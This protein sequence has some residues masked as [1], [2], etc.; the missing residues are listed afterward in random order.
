MIFAQHLNFKANRPIAFF[1][2]LVGV[3]ACGSARCAH[4]TIAPASLFTEGAVLQREEKVPVW[5]T[6]EPNEQITIELNGKT[7]SATASAAGQWRAD[8]PALSAGGPY[9]LKLSGSQSAPVSL[10]NVLV[11]E[12]WLCSGQSNMEYPLQGM[13]PDAITK[14]TIPTVKD[15]L[16]RFAKVERVIAL[17]PQA[18]VGVRWQEATPASAASISAVGYYFARELRRTLGVPVGLIQSAYGGTPAQGWTSREALAAQPG[19]ASY[20]A[21]IDNYPTVTYP[22]LLADFNAALPERQ[23]KYDAAK[24]V[25]DAAVAAGTMP[26]PPRPDR[27]PL[28]P[29]P[30]VEQWQRG[31]SQL[32]NAM[33]APLIP[34]R[35]RGVLW[36][37]GEDNWN[38]GYEYK[39]LLPTLIT[40]WRTR[41]GQGDFPFYI[42]QLPPHET[43][44][45]RPELSWLAEVREA[46]RQTA[47]NV[48]NSGLVVTTD[49]GDERDIHP[50]RKEPIGMRLALL[51]RARAYGEKVESSGPLF[52]GISVEGAQVRVRFTHAQGLRTAPITDHLDSGRIVATADKVL[53]F[54][55]AGAD[56]KFY[57]ASAKIEGTSVVLSAPEVP[58]PKTVRYGWSQY[59]LANLQNDAGLWASP[60]ETPGGRWNSQPRKATGALTSAPVASP[61]PQSIAVP[62]RASTQSTPQDVG[63]KDGGFE[64]QESWKLSQS[65]VVPEAAHTG[66]LGLRIVDNDPKYGSRASSNRITVVPGEAYRLSFWFKSPKDGTGAVQLLFSGAKG[67]PLWELSPNLRVRVSADWAPATMLLKVPEGATSATVV[68]SSFGGS[69]T[70]FDVDDVSLE[71]ATEAETLSLPTP[72]IPRDAATTKRTQPAYIILKLDD[73]GH[74][75]GRVPEPWKRLGAFLKE[76]RIPAS[77]G[78]VCNSLEGDNPEYFAWIK[79][80]QESGL[81]EFWNHG[82]THREWDENGRHYWEFDGRPYEEQKQHI[83]R[84]EQLAREKLGFPLTAFG[85]PF[86]ATDSNTSRA[87]AASNDIKVN[88]YGDTTEQA[89]KIILDRIG[90]VNIESP[91][92]S[93]N[94][95][96]LVKG[97]NAHPDQ[98]FFVIQGHPAMWTGARW[99]Q[100]SKIIDFLTE[101]KAIF[102]QP[103]RYAEHMKLTPGIAARNSLL[104]TL[105]VAAQTLV[106]PPASAAPPVPITSVT[107]ATVT[108]TAT[109]TAPQP[110]VVNGD[111]AASLEGTWS[112]AGKV[113]SLP[114]LIDVTIAGAPNI[115]RALQIGLEAVPGAQP[116]DV[117][118]IAAKTLPAIAKKDLVA[119]QMWARATPGTRFNVIFQQNSE[120]FSKTIRQILAL[121]PQWRHITL[122]APAND[123]YEAN[124]S[125]FELQV[126]QTTGTLEIA[127]V[128]V[129]NLGAIGMA[130]AKNRLG[131]LSLDYYGTATPNDDWMPAALARI[132]KYRKASVKVQV[133]DSKGKPVPNAQVVLDETHSA[134]R[135]GT[136][137]NERVLEHSPD[138]DKYR[139]TLK[140]LFNTAVPGNLLKW[141][142]TDGKSGAQA[143][144]MAVVDWL[145]ANGFAVRG[146]NVVWGG[147]NFLPVRVLKLPPDALKAEVEQR[148]KNAMLPYRGKLYV[149]DVVNE[150]GQEVDMWNK[151]GWDQF[152]RVF[153]LAKE[154]DPNVLLAYNDYNIANEAPDN[155][156]LRRKVEDRIQQL[157]NAKVPLDILGDQAHM[158]VPLTPLPRVLQIWDEWK[159]KYGKVLE[160][161]EFDVDV[162]DD[163]I[164]A[165]Y[166]HDFLIAAFSEPNIESF[167]MWGFWA[168]D[169]WRG[170]PGSLFRT[171]W[172]P[173]P[174]AI[175]YEDLVLKQW[176]THATLTTDKTGTATT[177]VFLGDYDVQVKVGGKV[178]NT[179]AVVGKV[180]L[181]LKLTAP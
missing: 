47:L 4:A 10:K 160:V 68:V 46:Q 15:P 67:Q 168:K 78:I 159:R 65:M 106:A 70:T 69:I 130:E 155:G 86:N 111:F 177:R 12:V 6:A 38:K 107:P 132:E 91:T 74:S 54:T 3:L 102:I 43:I 8:L 172:S 33:I 156:V 29:P 20:N 58:D 128:R 97:Y 79:E 27:R 149:W 81:V 92:F 14:A 171:D 120:P 5:G 118:L 19:L 150:A 169:H 17:K 85:A 134:F 173:R 62:E 103:T 123:G 95:E 37:Q 23:Q 87:L 71:K 63:L 94:L 112:V 40:D 175:A 98:K 83:E 72:A 167:L 158:S 80:L 142:F 129:E 144:G 114:R 60:F 113:K 25:Y 138:G 136:E 147:N 82:Y 73:L 93:P 105:T 148:V 50:Y 135:W 108:T 104:P 76:R 164:H 176:R 57:N 2:L 31:S 84:S 52:E 163:A 39:T 13:S 35:L 140:R 119:V 153:Q 49:V 180:G 64:T 88:M 115:K 41:W 99:E 166:T 89:G 154:T 137:V 11:G 121:T 24:A 127:D 143:T 26:L 22:K 42:V 174:A 178:Q 1:P 100:F 44:N 181:Q 145:G 90:A 7:A 126:G 77:I 125:N 170:E 59:P 55:L 162:A 146:H 32:Y 165:K 157:I 75:K 66:A 152:P 21:E 28:T 110:L 139:E 56:G 161:T 124:G 34:Y 48:P 51:A 16:L 109:T 122:Y 53:G 18:R 179:K 131:A 36:Y 96:A 151:I 141:K 133:V 45:A 9:V 117:R 61:A 30:P 101:Q 116:W